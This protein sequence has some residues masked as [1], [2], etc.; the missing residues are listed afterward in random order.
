MDVRIITLR[1]NDGLGGFPEDELKKAISG[2]E[3]LEVREHFY[4]YGNIPHITMLVMLGDKYLKE[5]G[6]RASG[7]DPVHTLPPHL[8]KLYG[9]LRYWRNE[10]AKKDGVPSYVIMRNSQIADICQ[11]MPR[12][13]T[14]LKEIEGIGEATCSKYG[15]EV[16]ALIPEPNREEG[17]KPVESPEQ[18]EEPTI[19]SEESI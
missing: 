15:R 14:A 1:Y 12:S 18:E 17:P 4:M 2:R 6:R 5:E 16:L 3:V 9:D 13:L 11:Q 7:E 8:Q 10:R 19:A